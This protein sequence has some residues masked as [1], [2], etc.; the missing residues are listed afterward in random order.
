MIGIVVLGTTDAADELV[1]HLRHWHPFRQ[2]ETAG[3][4]I[5]MARRAAAAALNLEQFAALDEVADRIG[6]PRSI[7]RVLGLP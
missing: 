6:F 2:V 4:D 7:S 5:E 1:G 3:I